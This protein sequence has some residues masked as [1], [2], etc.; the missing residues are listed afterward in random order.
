MI[1]SDLFH[2]RIVSNTVI[3]S[4]EWSKVVT[5][6]LGKIEFSVDTENTD[7]SINLKI[8]FSSKVKRN[9]ILFS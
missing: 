4:C 7:D 3:L 9:F 6:V 5:D 8:V 2:K 1:F